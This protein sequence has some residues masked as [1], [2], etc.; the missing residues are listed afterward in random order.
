MLYSTCVLA[1]CDLNDIDSLEAPEAISLLENCTEVENKYMHHIKLGDSYFR[2][3]DLAMAILNYEKARTYCTSDEYLNVNLTSAYTQTNNGAK[4]LIISEI[5]S[6]KHTLAS[7]HLRDYWA[8]LSLILVLI[9]IYLL[10]KRSELNS[11]LVTK[12]RPLVLGITVCFLA[13]A[14]YSLSLEEQQAVVMSDAVSVYE[15][16][17]GT[18]DAI[19]VLNSGYKLEVIEL[20]GDWARVKLATNQKVWVKRD[21]LAFI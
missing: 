8:V 10:Y 19:S 3:N 13:M 2:N 20:S 5:Q 14:I 1:N 16:T 11:S 12:L 15:S 7:P 6:A 9:C 17:S 21:V 18:T 4:T